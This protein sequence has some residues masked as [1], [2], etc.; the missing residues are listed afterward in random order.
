[1]SESL[2]LMAARVA[3]D[4]HFLA[5][6]LAAFS[7]AHGLS[8]CDLIDWLDL[9]ADRLTQLRL[10]RACRTAAECDAVAAGVGCRADRLRGIVGIGD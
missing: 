1:M 3:S 7:Q 9:P 10:C 5:H 6:Q 2:D 8:D 4:P